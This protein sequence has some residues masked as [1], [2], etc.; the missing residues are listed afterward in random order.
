M[1]VNLNFRTEEATR[2]AIDKLAATID[3]DRSWV[4]NQA[5]KEYLDDNAWH[6]EH[7]MEGLRDIEEGRTVSLEEVKEHFKQ[8]YAKTKAGEDK[9]KGAAKK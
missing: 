7:I 5:V 6:I 9:K 4:I 3:R 2:D 1:S 8:R